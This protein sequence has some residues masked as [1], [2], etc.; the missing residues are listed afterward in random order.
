MEWLLLVVG[1]LVLIAASIWRDVSRKSARPPAASDQESERQLRDFHRAQTLGHSHF[2]G[3]DNT[4]H[5][6]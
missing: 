1:G 3:L 6:R 4:G 5:R 2:V